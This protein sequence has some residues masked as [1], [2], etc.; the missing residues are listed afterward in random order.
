[1]IK[2]ILFAILFFNFTVICFAEKR[3]EGDY[4]KIYAQEDTDLMDLVKKLDIHSQYLLDKPF[5]D[6]PEMILT[7]VLDA[8]FLETSDILDI[9]LYNYRGNI[10]IY[11]DYKR[12]KEEFKSLFNEDLT[13]LSFYISSSNTIYI[14][15]ENIK[16]EI[17]AHEIAHALINRY[18][19][20]SPPIKVQEILAK[21][22]EYKI[23][24]LKR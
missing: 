21:Y 7:E 13:A 14:D 10:K 19:V 20:V 4:F 2:K 23:R 3:F 5:L 17:L 11:K 8:I 1:M 22:V 6:K 24:R 16:P 9:H 12:L 15:A 18:F